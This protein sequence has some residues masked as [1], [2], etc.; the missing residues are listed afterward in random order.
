MTDTVPVD[1]AQEA[2]FT[3]L[4][5]P[6]RHPQ[7]QRIDTHAASVFLEGDRALK[8]KRAVRFPFL[9]YSTLEKRKAA[10][11]DEIRINKPFAPDIYH[12]V[13]PITRMT[14]GSLSIGGAGE[15]VE[16]AVEMARFDENQTLD[17][18]AKCGELNEDLA[19]RMADAIA[20]SHHIA[21]SAPTEPWVNSIQPVIDGYIRAF[22]AGAWFAGQEVDAL[23]ESSKSAF[24]R[25]K[26]DLQDRGRRGYIRRCHGDLHLANIVLI[27]ESPVLFDAIEFDEQIASVD[28]LYDLA[29]PL[30]DL[31]HYGQDQAANHLLNRYLSI[32]AIDHLYGLAALPLFQSMRSAIRAEVLLARLDRS[33]ADG[34]EILE[35]A[36]AYFRL[37]LRLIQPPPPA[38]VAVGGLSGSGKS[39]LARRLAPL[40]PPAPGAVVLRSDVL[41]KRLFNIPESE[42]LPE[43]AYRPEI[44]ARVYDDMMQRA[45]RIVSHGHSA[46]LDAVFAD[47]NERTAARAAATDAKVNFVGLFLD[48]DLATRQARVGSRRAD[49]SDAT[50]A[51][52]A[53]QEQ[54]ALGRID[55]TR[56]DASG[57]LEATLAY[58]QSRLDQPL[59]RSSQVAEVARR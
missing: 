14:D 24:G 32:T 3:F 33:G 55:W 58:C 7:V 54:Y 2:V 13:V 52:A 22:K 27:G 44:T 42:R 46:V 49:A 39:V 5:D 21:A 30:M 35:Q 12:G 6:S 9:D 25:L 4:S 43:A 1:S 47:E 18:L 31:M 16:Y 10:C 11:E 59:P 23:R 17:H 36:T 26:T 40:I 45:V 51:V 8:I 28:V 41:R 48:A 19:I 15:P 34:A 53:R 20:A 29:F 37:A 50:P 38:M 56:V 57:P